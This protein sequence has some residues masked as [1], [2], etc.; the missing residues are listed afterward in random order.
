MNY[1][2]QKITSAARIGQKEECR[3]AEQEARVKTP[4]G[5]LIGVFIL[6][7]TTYIT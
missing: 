6:F 1:H 2:L 4:V 3:S 5:P 7:Y